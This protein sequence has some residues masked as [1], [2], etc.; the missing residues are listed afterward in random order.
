M[1]IAELL[2]Y[3]HGANNII[4]LK[5]RNIKEED[6]FE[7]LQEIRFLFM[8]NFDIF[9]QS[10]D[11]EISLNYL[12]VC[13]AIYNVSIK[14]AKGNQIYQFVMEKILIPYIKF[15]NSS[16]TKFKNKYP[17]FFQKW[18]YSFQIDRLFEVLGIYI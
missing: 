9:Q 17:G 1:K 4:N 6:I 16:K 12:H 7:L 15:P 2:K 8:I 5:E 11:E 3:N 13:I 14:Q 10:L 18:L